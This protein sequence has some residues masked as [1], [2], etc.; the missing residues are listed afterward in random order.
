MEL[1]RF[2]SFGQFENAVVN[3]DLKVRLLGTKDGRWRLGHTD[4]GGITVQQGME[5]VPNLCE[6]SGWPTHL[7]FLLS[8]GR[9]SATWLNG[10]PFAD[11]KVGVLAPRRGFVFRAE[12]PNEWT[13]IALPLASWLLNADNEAGRIL[14]GWTRSTQ[15]L[16]T[17]P[18]AIETLK[19]A[20]LIASA[21]CTPTATGRL[22]IE[23]AIVALVHSRRQRS[24]AI[25]RPA[26]SPHALCDAT[27]DL[28][29]LM[30]GTASDADRLDGLPLG[31][32]SLRSFFHNCFGLGPV[33]Y[34]HLRRLHAIHWALLNAA[35]GNAS[36]AETF[37]LH[38]YA[39][40]SY[41]LGQYRR[42]F[43]EAP[44]ATRERRR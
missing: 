32:R 27:L 38:G 10:V 40:S 15:M 8:P 35:R 36:I 4:V 1:Q 42:I 7:M 37:E 24:A 3:V 39:Y 28:F 44:S 23:N 18:S 41:A 31:R 22:L 14:R 5:T 11:G 20:A 33:Q 13:T 12:G 2:E 6:A 17:T 26:V 19:H 21:P 29:D 16:D 25:G 30:D 34:L 43:G 9:P